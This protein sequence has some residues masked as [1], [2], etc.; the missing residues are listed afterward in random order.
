VSYKNCPRSNGCF[1]LPDYVQAEPL[2]RG[3]Y[4]TKYIPRGTGGTLPRAEGRPLRAVRVSSAVLKGANIAGSSIHGSSLAKS[5]LATSSLSGSSLGN[6]EVFDLVPTGAD[7][8]LNPYEGGQAPAPAKPA[9]PAPALIVGGLALA[10]L[11][12]KK[13]R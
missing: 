7:E 9:I 3:A 4:A 12:L 6:M 8:A 5:S 1:T 2:N 11:L 10:W 13:R